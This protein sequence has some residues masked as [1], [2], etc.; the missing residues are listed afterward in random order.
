MTH[1]TPAGRV[2][3]FLDA[4]EDPGHPQGAISTQRSR[5]RDEALRLTVADLRAV[6]AEN[7]AMRDAITRLWK[8]PLHAEGHTWMVANADLSRALHGHPVLDEIA[9]DAVANA[10]PAMLAGLPRQQSEQEANL[11][12]ARDMLRRPEDAFPAAA[13]LI[14]SHEHGGWWRPFERGYTSD[15][16]YA[17]RYLHPRAYQICREAN[18]YGWIN[19]LPKEVMIEWTDD[20]QTAA[21]AVRAATDV[22]IA[23]RTA[24]EATE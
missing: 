21:A 6:L 17:G 10:L 19:G 12:A 5:H 15:L 8:L 22:L 9:A 7:Q 3:A 18:A 1:D 20:P 14:W 11:R 4:F 13:W 2:G 23:E 16:A 24:K